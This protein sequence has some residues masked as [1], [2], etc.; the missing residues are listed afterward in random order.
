MSSCTPLI[1]P[2]NKEIIIRLTIAT[3]KEVDVDVAT[4]L[5]LQQLPKNLGHFA[6][7][8]FCNELSSPSTPNNV[9]FL[10][11]VQ[12][13]V[14]KSDEHTSFKCPIDESTLF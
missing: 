7:F 3:T 2:K 6:L 13:I 14:E 11:E 1:P 10:G 9:G 12:A 4:Y 8:L 5:N